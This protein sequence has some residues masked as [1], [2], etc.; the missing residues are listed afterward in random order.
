MHRNE[1]YFRWGGGTVVVWLQNAGGFARWGP[2]DERV[3]ALLD[4]WRP[5]AKLRVSPAPAAPPPAAPAPAPAAHPP[6]S[7]LPDPDAQPQQDHP[8][9]KR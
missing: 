1:V 2:T 4:A 3:E 5:R 8:P 7:A 6:P 9:D